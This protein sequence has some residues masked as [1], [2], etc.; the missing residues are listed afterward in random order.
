M[1]QAYIRVEETQHYTQWT[2]DR[3][4]RGNALGPT[5]AG[6]LAALL[7]DFST[8]KR[9]PHALVL[10]ASPVH[11]QT[12]KIWIAGG[13]LKELATLD[14]AQEAMTFAQAIGAFLDDL[15]RLPGPVIIAIEG[16]AIGGGA[17]LAL[18]GDIRIATADARFEFKQT[19]M[20]LPT[21]FGGATRL[22][23]LIG[24]TRAETLVYGAQT[25]EASQAYEWGLLHALARDQDD[26][27]SVIASWVQQLVS[28]DPRAFA[29]QKAM[30]YLARGGQGGRTTDTEARLFGQAWK[31]PTHQE[32]LRQ[33]LARSSRDS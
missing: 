3:P 32:S 12:R 17:E 24:I 16:D 19:T 1:A 28:I 5:I 10:T 13:D 2:I 26:L 31:N 23:Q 27:R 11:T 25:L 4:R 7:R 9:A 8:Q 29:A 20:G 22:R 14:D 33:F 18:G 30:F 21:G 6:Q 15:A